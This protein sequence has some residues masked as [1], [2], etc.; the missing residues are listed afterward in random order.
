[1]NQVLG[2][3]KILNNG[4]DSDRLNLVILA[5]GYTDTQQIEFANACNAIVTAI[6][7]E[8]WFGDLINAINVFRIDVESN[9][10]GAD[11]PNCDGA[12][13]GTTADT[14]LMLLFAVMV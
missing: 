9:D 11:D 6:Q 4:P 3:T 7:N 2:T 13:P 10:S 14:F 1:M 5:E 12:G 8:P